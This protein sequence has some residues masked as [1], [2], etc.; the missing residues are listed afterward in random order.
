MIW[1]LL[2][3]DFMVVREVNKDYYYC[4]VGKYCIIL[5]IGLKLL[6]RLLL[7]I[8][9]KSVSGISI[10]IIGLYVVGCLCF[11]MS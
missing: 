3:W 5:D 1:L 6:G 7:L 10:Y 9:Y 11:F 2:C 8:Y 4:F